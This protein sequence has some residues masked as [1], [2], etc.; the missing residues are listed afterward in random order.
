MAGKV[1]ARIVHGSR[2][3]A[4]EGK[5]LFF[6]TFTCRG[7][8]LN[9]ESAD[10]NYYEWTNK[11]LTNLR[12]KA[13]RQGQPWVYVQVTERQQRG[14]AHSHFVHTFAPDDS[15]VLQDSKGRF[16]LESEGFINAV[17]AAG[18]GPQCQI[19]VIETPEAVAHY[20]SGYLEKH[21]NSDLF[22]RSWRRVRWSKEWPDLPP[23]ESEYSAVLRDRQAWSKIDAL[24]H[25]FL[26]END[27]MYQYARKRMV[28]VMPALVDLST[29]THYAGGNVH[30]N[31]SK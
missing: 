27:T 14:A 21:A 31:A 15:Q 23:F 2:L 4:S 18:L 3:L 29:K 26:A 10:D 1:R 22:P 7:R 16:S 17:V 9:L 5:P 30:A 12:Q 13:K 8:D 19:T 11:A 28:H 6:W 20:I 25:T 24:G